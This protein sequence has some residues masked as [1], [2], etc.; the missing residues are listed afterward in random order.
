MQ[1]K[2]YRFQKPE[3]FWKLSCSSRV[4]TVFIG[5]NFRLS[6]ASDKT[7]SM[8]D[9]ECAVYIMLY[10]DQSFYIFHIYV[11]IYI[12]RSIA[13]HRCVRFAVPSQWRFIAFAL[14]I[15][16][17]Y[18]STCPPIPHPAPLAVFVIA[19]DNNCDSV[20]LI[21]SYLAYGQELQEQLATVIPSKGERVVGIE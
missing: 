6:N 12:Y 3:S 17:C 18:S 20:G 8:C 5:L 9:S 19:S 1:A 2:Y 21:C 14:S 11:C 16:S 15:N 7:R 4:F 13:E 10:T